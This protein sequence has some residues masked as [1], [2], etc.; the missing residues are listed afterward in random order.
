[1]LI[2]FENYFSN[3]DP[4]LILGHEVINTSLE[5]LIKRAGALCSDVQFFSRLPHEF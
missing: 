5:F 2:N 3:A 4:D 1:M